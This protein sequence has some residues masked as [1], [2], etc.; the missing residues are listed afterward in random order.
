[1]FK[2]FMVSTHPRHYCHNLSSTWTPMSHSVKPS[3]DNH[4]ISYLFGQNVSTAIQLLKHILAL[5]NVQ[6]RS[7]KF[8]LNKFTSSYK[9]RLTT[10]LPLIML[11]ELNDIL[12]F[13]TSLKGPANEEFVIRQYFTFSSSSRSS[14]HNKLVLKLAKSNMTHTSAFLI[15]GMFFLQSTSA[16]ATRP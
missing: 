13:V 1:M 15:Y 4:F 14:V 2:S 6:R 9:S 5:E 10:L 11:Y 16:G 12:L 8:I 7:I 3:P